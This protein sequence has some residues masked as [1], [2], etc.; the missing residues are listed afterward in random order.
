[1][2]PNKPGA[3][4]SHDF[5]GAT[6]TGGNSTNASLRTGPTNC[7]RD[8]ETPKW[9]SDGT[10]RAKYPRADRSG[11]WAPTL[12]VN[13]QPVEPSDFSA[14]YS[15][16]RRYDYAEIR[17]FPRN[18]RVIA[19]SSKGGPAVVNGIRV[20]SFRCPGGY[21]KPG[22]PSP[23]GLPRQPDAATAP[24]CLT[25]RLDLDIRFPDC[26]NGRDSDS[27]D[28]RSHMAYSY[29]LDSGDR[30]CPP[31]F[32]VAV[33]ALKL[34]IRYATKGGPTMVLASGRL[35]TAHAD[36]M[37]GWSPARLAQ[38][39]RDCLNVDTYCGGGSAPQHA[40]R[41]RPSRCSRR[42]LARR[43]RHRGQRGVTGGRR[44]DTKKV[45][46]AR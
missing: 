3:S 26:W 24:T 13:D 44:C 36:F 27:P 7:V 35:A 2:S 25:D 11:Y 32:P 30:A 45:R 28:H 5:A 42:Q 20:Y 8:D 4:H 29:E 15:A 23:P 43:Q 34:G 17:P 41:K 38:L 12:Y 6:T 14:A 40:G 39:V 9:Q 16:G 37:N 18:L 31:N 21:A 46:R 19:G 33:P 1:V 22:G 10:L